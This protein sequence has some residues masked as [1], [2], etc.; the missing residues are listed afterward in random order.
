M[1][2]CVLYGQ[3]IIN[4]GGESGD[5]IRMLPTDIGFYKTYT[6]QIYL[7]TEIAQE[8]EITHLSFDFLGGNDISNSNTWTIYLG[9]TDKTEFLTNEDWISNSTLTQVFSGELAENPSSGWYEIT[10]DD[11]FFYNNTYNLVIAILQN[12]DGANADG[13]NYFGS[14]EPGISARSI[15]VRTY[16]EVTG[17][18]DPDNP[19][20]FDDNPDLTM[21]TSLSINRIKLQIIEPFIC[22]EPSDLTASS[23]TNNQALLGWTENGSSVQ[24]EIEYGLTG[25]AQG[26]GNL[27]TDITENPFLL[28][29]LSANSSYQFY[30]RAYCGDDDY[31]DWAGPFQFTTLCGYNV[32]FLES[33]EVGY[34]AGADIGAVNNNPCM[35]QQSEAGSNKWKTNDGSPY[36]VAY[37][38]DWNANL[39][40]NNT[41]WIFIPVSLSNEKMYSFSMFA[42]RSSSSATI[43]VKYGTLNSAAGMTTG[44]IVNSSAIGTEY[45]ELTGVIIPPATGIYYIGIKGSIPS[46]LN[47]LSIDDISVTEISCPY[48]SGLTYSDLT[49]TS[50]MI[51]WTEPANAPSEGYQYYYSLYNL[52]PD[53]NT[54]PS[55]SVSAGIAEAEI[56]GLSPNK[57]YYFW[58]RAV[59]NETENDFSDW[60]DYGTFR[61]ECGAAYI[62]FFEGF[63]D[64]FV[65]ET[66]I[67]GCYFQ[68]HVGGTVRNWEAFSGFSPYQ[69]NW[70]AALYHSTQRWLFI[71]VYLEQDIEYNFSVFALG[72]GSITVKYGTGSTAA[73][74]TNTI[75]G[76]AVITSSYLEYSNV[77]TPAVSGEYFIGVLGVNTSGTSYLKIDNFDIRKIPSAEI[78]GTTT[79][80]QNATGVN[81]SFVNPEDLP[82]KVTYNVNGGSNQIL[83]IAA[84]LSVDVA[85]PTNEPETLEYYLLSVEYQDLPNCPTVIDQTVTVTIE[86]Q[87]YAGIV[88]EDQNIM[89]GTQPADISL[90][91]ATGVVQ[92]EMADDIGFITNPVVVGTDN[93]VL[94][95]EDIGILTDTKYF[96]AVVTNGVCES[97][98][99]DVVTVTVTQFT[100]NIVLKDGDDPVANPLNF[101]EYEEGYAPITE[102]VIT[103]ESTGTGNIENIVVE[104][105]GD[106]ALSFEI[107]EPLLTILDN[108]NPTTTFTVKP[109]DDLEPGIY[110]AT[111]IVSADNEVEEGFAVEMT[112]T[113][114]PLTYTIVLKEGDD[115]VADPLNFGEYEEGY[116]PITEKV[117][118]MER[119]GT[120]NIE[121]IVVELTG[122]D[123]LSFEITEP[124]LTILDND[125]PAT[126]FT[127]K[128]Q[129][130]LEPGIYNATVIVTAD[131]EVEASFAVVFTV[132]EISEY[133]VV[134]TVTN[135]AEEPIA[136]AVINIHDVDV[137]TTGIDGTASIELLNGSYTYDVTA[138][139]Y[140]S[141]N[142][143]VFTVNNADENIFI[144]L[145]SS[146]VFVKDDEFYSYTVYP[147]PFK[148]FLIINTENNIY[149]DIKLMNIA[150]E[151][152]LEIN[153][154]GTEELIQ[155]L[156]SLTP[157]IYLLEITNEKIKQFNYKIIKN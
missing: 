128:P 73:D 152:I 46:S 146:T 125:N 29:G 43:E 89:S 66:T 94:A 106:D 147:N 140:T 137:L 124:L 99:S 92:W 25:F 130:D 75:I 5:F 87:S 72:T 126:T 37:S 107:T 17:N 18:I 51:K 53:E 123:A 58:V 85:V 116:S 8:G 144:T 120:G 135:V 24:W 148:D 49:Q 7:Q 108:D 143:L 23:I 21:G 155:D 42:K 91:E 79:V 138:D 77:F 61:T 15:Y 39:Y 81:V 115:P 1:I 119:T 132:N 117:I 19:G 93:I 35:S 65:N 40:H 3:S 103:I 129:D 102:K 9:H 149:S 104:L 78:L 69:G 31:T 45:S 133:L 131:N 95:G 97:V 14:F 84:N 55:G 127:I 70:N 32:P 153:T 154:S 136:G 98:F 30:V 134:F 90:S 74:M 2:N 157:G 96:R 156:E 62:P 109:Q 10:L 47:Y 139:T 86:P 121:N 83:N 67:A 26:N 44:T 111:V 151:V 100:Y 57:R 145:V 113:A 64:G 33:F 59:C 13:I 34:T 118:T 122:D 11:S 48:P 4:I 76:S 6:Q 22:L 150:G 105:T 36:P 16:Y 20:N 41:D 27:V 142:G 110:N 50:A 101:G 82:V 28:E 88:S 63:E 12:K 56:T 60:T 52:A 141:L 114:T 68:E 112:V 71:P 38:G 54:I 80:C